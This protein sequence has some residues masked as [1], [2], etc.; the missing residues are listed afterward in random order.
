MGK[1]IMEASHAISEAVKMVKPGVIAAYPITPQT[2]IVEKISEFVADGELDSQY[3][4]AESE[5][6]AIS[7]CLGAS[8]TGV[9]SYT[10]TAS[11]GLALM[12]EVLFIISGMRLPVCMTLANRSISAPIS[13]WNDH[14]DSI[15]IRDTGWIQLYA[16][17][18]QE[19]YD[20]TI[21]QFRISEHRRV[22]L[23]SMVC[24]DGFVLT[25]LYEPLDIH[26]QEEVDDFLP[27]Y[28][29]FHAILDPKQPLTQGPIGFPSHYMELRKSQIDATK[30]S[31]RIIESIFNEF[32]K[33][34]PV[35]IKNSRPDDYRVI[36]EYKTDDADIIFVAMGSICG[37]IKVVI[38]KLRKN[39]EKA[40]L[41]K[42][43]VYRPFPD[44]AIRK[45][46]YNADKVAVIERAVSAGAN[47][48]IF[49]EIRSLFYDDS[50]RPNIRSFIAGIGGR[51]V[52]LKHI[53][54]IYY[55]VKEDKGKKEE[56]MF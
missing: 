35:E 23:P 51:D 42:I 13:I 12:F 32:S 9:R 3:I 18:A 45:A 5:F 44:D 1:Q 41:A 49:D 46:L 21:M 38:D 39:G 16:E 25:H 37:Q 40:G 33:K 52:T 28:E 4:R 56:W 43:V 47:A 48:P 22:L 31:L 27:E 34:F 50:R 17:T 30:G 54:K 53:E 19:C 36:E 24:M 29:P 7:A 26:R 10:A 11:Q 8:A 2:H 20:L 6:G 55:M 14:Q 15:S